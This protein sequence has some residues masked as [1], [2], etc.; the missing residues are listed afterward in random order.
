MP[1]AH[2]PLA[3]TDIDKP[4]AWRICDRCGRRRHYKD[5]DFQW[6]WQG[7][8]AIT[9]LHLIVCIDTCMDVPQ[10][11]GRKPIIIGPDPIPIKDPRPGWEYTQMAGTGIVGPVTVTPANTIPD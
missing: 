5:T 11:N 6:D 9:N 3:P 8:Q 10:P 7:A 1:L 4:I 2:S